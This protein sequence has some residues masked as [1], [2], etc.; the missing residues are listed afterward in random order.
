MVEREAE[1]TSE[2]MECYIKKVLRHEI[3][4]AFLFESGLGECSHSSEM[5]A[6]DEEIVDWFARQGDK[7]YNTWKE[8]GAL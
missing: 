6:K 4:H 8:V 5:W 3:V 1:G 7:I 2:D